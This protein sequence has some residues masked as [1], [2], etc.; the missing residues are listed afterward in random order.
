M[1]KQKMQKWSEASAPESSV[2]NIG[3]AI[4]VA[5][6]HASLR[7]LLGV[8]LKQAAWEMTHGEPVPATLILENDSTGRQHVMEGYTE[9]KQ[10][11]VFSECVHHAV[12][13]VDPLRSTFGFHIKGAKHLLSDTEEAL[14]FWSA[15][16]SERSLTVAV[17]ILRSPTGDF[18]M[19]GEEFD[20][21]WDPKLLHH[22]FG[23]EEADSSLPSQDQL[24]GNLW[25]NN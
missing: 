1:K 5:L 9:K 12:L 3:D 20:I 6:L 2:S 25:G 7:T 17:P 22:A 21:E 23:E 16:C 18:L 8:K 19:F 15:S 14:I 10:F 13:K 4:E 11:R 24:G